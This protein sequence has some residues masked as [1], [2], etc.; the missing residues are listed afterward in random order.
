MS[1]NAV[2]MAA[3]NGARKNKIHHLNLP[4]SISE[5][6]EEAARCFA[7][8]ATVLH[9]HVRNSSEQHVLD[10]GL[11]QE[12]F[13]EMALQV[14]EM[15]LQMTTEAVGKYSPEQQ[16]QCVFALRP[17][18]ISISVREMAGNNTDLAHA[19]KFY[20]WNAENSVHM[21]HIVYDAA[22]LEHLIKLQREGVVPVGKL[23]VLFVL[24]RFIEN[25]EA[26]PEDIDPFLQVAGDTIMDWFVC[27]FGSHEHTCA[28]SALSRGGHARVGFENNLLL[29]D[30]SQAL[31]TA[32]LVR[33][34]R[35]DAEAAGINVVNAAEARTLLGVTP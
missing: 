7:D 25:R 12:L 13:N 5:T 23:C 6:V 16:A 26:T 18:M 31:H 21:Q 11:Y 27:A 2:I 19:Q 15:L 4:V 29:K 28:L 8:G 34:L 30:G 33:A 22:D 9:A 14:P 1:H 17:T 10:S 3:P 24:G 35:I 20:H 32:D